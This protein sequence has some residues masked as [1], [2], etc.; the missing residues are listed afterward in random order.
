MVLVICHLIICLISM[1]MKRTDSPQSSFEVLYL[2]QGITVLNA[3]Q[4]GTQAIWRPC[5]A[6]A[7]SRE[8]SGLASCRPPIVG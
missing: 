3:H 2:P 6:R 1:Q 7:L 8:L 5:T 4:L